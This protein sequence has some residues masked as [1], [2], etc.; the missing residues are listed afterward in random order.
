MK[1]GVTKSISKML[2]KK[3]KTHASTNIQNKADSPPKPAHLHDYQP[4][5]NT[6]IRQTALDFLTQ[7]PENSYHCLVSRWG[8]AT[9]KT[10]KGQATYGRLHKQEETIPHQLLAAGQLVGDLISIVHPLP[11]NL[12]ETLTVQRYKVGEGLGKHRD[13]PR[14]NPFVLGITLCVKKDDTRKIVFRHIQNKTKHELVTGDGNVYTFCGDAYTDW[15]HESA[16][17]KKQKDTIYSLTF[18]AAAK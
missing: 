2:T 8:P 17:S 11:S 1:L 10:R 3:K 4:F 5:I 18:R 14:H 7:L 6:T 13:P 9:P 12:L 16:K 15:T